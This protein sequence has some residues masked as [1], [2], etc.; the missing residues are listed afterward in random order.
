MTAAEALY[1]LQR[2]EA[3]IDER[4]RRLAQVEAAL[5]PP[6][7]LLAARERLTHAQEA[8]A[9]QRRELRK[10]EADLQ[11]LEAK[12][13]T[14]ERKL[15]SGTVR[16]PKELKNLQDEVSALRRARDELQEA[17]LEVMLALEEAEAGLAEGGRAGEAAR[18]RP[19]SWRAPKRG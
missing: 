9:G 4:S 5:N 2:V 6:P 18:A 11:A 16:N 12:I 3:E 8:V 7:G 13:A 19:A 17:I 10:R 15:Y 14:E 1:R